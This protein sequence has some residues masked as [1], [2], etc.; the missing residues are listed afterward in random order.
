MASYLY[1]FV[2]IIVFLLFGL[3]LFQKRPSKYF[4]MTFICV[5]FECYSFW[6]CSVAKNSSEAALSCRNL[7]LGAVWLNFFI[8][9]SIADI[10][11]I[12]LPR[13]V[14]VLATVAN[15]IMFGLSLTIGLNPI[16]YK[17]IDVTFVHGSTVMVK[18]YGPAHAVYFWFVLIYMVAT[19]GVTIYGIRNRSVV[20]YKY[21]ILILAIVVVNTVVYFLRIILKPTFDFAS[22]SYVISLAIMYYLQYR[23]ELY[24]STFLEAGRQ[25]LD[26]K[27]IIYLDNNLLYMGC[28]NNASYILPELNKFSLERPVPEGETVLYQTII[29]WVIEFDQFDKSSTQ[30]LELKDKIYRC[31]ISYYKKRFGLIEKNIGFL[32]VLSDDTNQQNYINSLNAYTQ[33]LHIK[34]EELRLQKE[35]AEK[36]LIKKQEVIDELLKKC[37]NIDDKS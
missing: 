3:L 25:V 32:I 36:E 27:A 1:F 5:F 10:C 30:I 19:L 14:V 28:S 15:T 20:S 31:E 21:A 11:A 13:W 24:D 12:K 7:Y 4:I 8:L 16:Y 9:V 6:A 29:P 26:D 23:I 17:G 33:K 37:G 22:I 35:I 34:E 2:F 18:E